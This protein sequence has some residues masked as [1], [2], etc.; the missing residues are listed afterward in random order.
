MQLVNAAPS[1]LQLNE[2][3]SDDE[4]ENDAAAELDGLGGFESIVVSGAVPSYVKLRVA[5]QPE[6]F[7]AVS[8]ERACQLYEPSAS[9]AG[10]HVAVEPLDTDDDVP[11]VTKPVH[12]VPAAADVHRAVHGGRVLPAAGRHSAP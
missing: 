10:V 9:D 12:C 6:R 5:L 4:N 3:L 1:R 11:L 8:C 2:P 7:P